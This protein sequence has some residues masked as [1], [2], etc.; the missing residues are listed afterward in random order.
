[1]SKRSTTRHGNARPPSRS[2]TAAPVGFVQ[3]KCNCGAPA[4]IDGE[5]KEC[6]GKRFNIQRYSTDRPAPAA[7]AASTSLDT[8]RLL[9]E[10]MD[11]TASQ[12]HSFA[13]VGLHAPAREMP[14]KSPLIQPRD[15][16]EQEA[17]SIAEHVT[18][19]PRNQGVESRRPIRSSVAAGSI[20][21]FAADRSSAGPEAAAAT[22]ASGQV[23]GAGRTTAPETA[24]G[25]LIAED[26]ARELAPG[27]MRKTEFLDQME[28]AVC[29]AAD[30]ELLAAGRSADGC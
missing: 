28:R 13:Q 1:M 7:S 23:P 15:P 14:A 30:A 27:Q 8:D 16:S 26:D 10:H 22:K 5:C 29:E 2:S 25:P 19:G 20:Q 11:S 21:R 4:G 3:R 12:G 6:N 18:H 17:D 24:A 9:P